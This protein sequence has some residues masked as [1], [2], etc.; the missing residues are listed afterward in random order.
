MPFG[1]G[2]NNAKIAIVTD[3]ATKE[4]V[5]KKIALSGFIGKKVAEFLI[6]K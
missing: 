2:P 4:E 1:H 5:K 6:H 3:Y